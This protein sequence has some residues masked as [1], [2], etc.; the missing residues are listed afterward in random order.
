MLEYCYKRMRVSD[1]SHFEAY[2][3]NSSLKVMKWCQ[4]KG[5]IFGR[6][7]TLQGESFLSTFMFISIYT[8]LKSDGKKRF[9]KLVSMWYIG[10]LSRVSRSKSKT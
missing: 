6:E 5:F 9:G 4:E 2:I 3:N 8:N 10:Y 7:H 1:L